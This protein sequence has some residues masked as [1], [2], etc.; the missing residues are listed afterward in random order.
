MKTIKDTR[1][2]AYA[3]IISK[4]KR[5]GEQKRKLCTCIFC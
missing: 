5:H 4:I 1:N 3:C 2:Y